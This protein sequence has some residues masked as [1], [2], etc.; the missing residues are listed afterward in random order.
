MNMSTK[1]EMLAAA[2]VSDHRW[3][4]VVVLRDRERVLV[5]H[6]CGQALSQA[7][8]TFAAWRDVGAM[9]DIFRRP[10]AFCCC[11]IASV[12]QYFK[13]FKHQGLIFSSID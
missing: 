4:V 2:T 3:A 11:I 6:R 5:M 10:V 13:R 9:L 12:N 1:N 7:E 8:E